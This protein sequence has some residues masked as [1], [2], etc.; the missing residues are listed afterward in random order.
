[1]SWF[2][3]GVNPILWGWRGALCGAT[4][5]RLKM[6]FL[7]VLQFVLVLVL[8]VRVNMP[9]LVCIL[10]PQTA[11]CTTVL[12]LELYRCIAQVAFLIQVRPTCSIYMCVCVYAGVCLSNALCKR[13]LFYHAN[14]CTLGGR[15]DPYLAPGLSYRTISVGEKNEDPVSFCSRIWSHGSATMVTR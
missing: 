1:M 2:L 10:S 11:A 7:K 13:L 3:F 12:V 8:R 14:T 4:A 6:T 9:L 15:R 5:T